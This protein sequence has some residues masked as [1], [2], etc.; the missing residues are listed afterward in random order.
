MGTRS[1]RTI[2]FTMKVSPAERHLLRIKAESLGLNSAEYL[3]RFIK[4][5]AFFSPAVLEPTVEFREHI[6]NA[7]AVIL[8]TNGDALVKQEAQIAQVSEMLQ[9]QLGKRT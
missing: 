5:E 1:E 7:L 4:D 9:R 8:V 3:R 6:C 2:Q